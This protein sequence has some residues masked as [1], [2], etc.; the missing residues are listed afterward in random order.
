[1]P[2]TI[3]TL[4]GTRYTLTD[5][6]V[7]WAA[8]SAQWEGPPAETA[9][10]LW[11]MTQGFARRRDAG[12]R[13]RS[14]SFGGYVRGFSQ[15]VNPLWMRDGEKC[16]P[17]GPY[18]GQDVCAPVRLDRRDQ[19]VRMTWEEINPEKRAIIQRW[20]AGSLPNPV[21]RAVDFGSASLVNSRI[22]SGRT[23]PSQIVLRGSNIYITEYG[24][25]GWLPGHVRMSRSAAGAVAQQ[26]LIV[27]PFV[28]AGAAAVGFGLYMLARR[29]TS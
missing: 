16:R 21:P 8:R 3:Y 2:A 22:A 4:R 15:P 9:A 17:G 1:M 29:R 18:A 12:G 28:I 25:E 26:A 14:E 7:L 20:V 6:D 10:I 23:Q 24:S 5:Q 19:A 11:T 27:A 13:F